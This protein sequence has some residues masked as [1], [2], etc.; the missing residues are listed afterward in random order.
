MRKKKNND[1]KW[2]EKRKWK[3]KKKKSRYVKL[4]YLDFFSLF[5]QVNML[6]KWIFENEVD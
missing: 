2:G 6:Q 5:R 4:Q 3:V 1:E